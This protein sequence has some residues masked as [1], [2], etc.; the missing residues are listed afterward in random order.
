M[1]EAYQSLRSL[2]RRPGLAVTVVLTLAVGIGATTAIFSVVDAMFLK[3]LPFPS[4]ERLVL[5]EEFKNGKSSNG[6]PLRLADWRAQVPGIESATGFYTEKLVLTG[7]GD[8]Q[9]LRA[10]RSFGPVLSV[11][12]V[13]PEMG[14]GF[15]AEEERGAP[16][17]LLTDGYWRRRFGGDPSLVGQTLDLDGK[18]HTIIGILPATFRY[19][20]KV[21]ALVPAPPEVQRASRK[22]SFLPTIARLKPGVS[23]AEAQAQITAV[24]D[25]L[26][27]QYPAT[28]KDLTARAVPLLAGET[29]EARTPVF[30]VLACVALVL[31][32]ACINVAG[33]LLARAA[34]RG[35][36]TAIRVSLGATRVNL[37][38][39]YLLESSILA[40]CGCASG[41]AFAAFGLDGLKLILPADLPRL[42]EASLDWRVAAFAVVLSFGCA[43]LFGIAPAW[44]ASRASA[45]S[46]KPRDAR[47]FVL[48]RALVALQVAL[49]FTLLIGAGLLGESFLHMK[50]TP[51][52]FTPANVLTVEINFP[53][54]AG[55]DMRVESFRAQALEAFSAI[56]GVMAV[57][58]G[59]R[60]PL[61]GG[62]QSGPISVRGRDLPP[63]LQE[64]ETFHRAASET[65]FQAIGIP[66][67]A[68]RLFA[69]G[70]HEA[71]IND[72]LAKKFF[73]DGRALGSAVSFDKKQWFEIVGIVG[74]VRQNSMAKAAP[75]EVYVSGADL[76]WPLSSFA[77]RIAGDP[78]AAIP[79]VREAVRRIDPNQ[80]I[81]KIGTMDSRLDAAYRE[82]MLESW[83]IFGF[84]MTAL[85]LTILG[86]YGLM[87]SDAIQRTRE[88]GVRIAVGARPA[89]VLA[90]MVRRGLLSVAPGIVIG[91]AA[92]AA[93]T[94][95]L[96]SLLF[97]VSPFDATVFAATAAVLIVTGMLASYL[98]ARRASRTDPVKALRAEN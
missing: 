46:A 87:A 75:E 36:E 22:A 38:R 4:P 98:P 1:R 92:A 26:R 32:T 93:L 6:N 2:A 74:D 69:A 3:P 51:L 29:S 63:A 61:D 95:F 47:A 45:S 15:T 28:D 55:T 39:L 80:V 82:P 62:T 85:L 48:R 33:L 5:I 8:A 90:M 67:K 10:M 53:W 94:R 97:G 41:L 17:A 24:A 11:L 34:E 18:P 59:D 7:R 16:V 31:L 71:V 81:D 91:I 13:R 66:L 76:G 89:Q 50:H 77:L 20:E 73:P 70:K 43:L 86:I 19:P 88:I 52:G 40:A 37:V 23:L 49:S 68:G 12:G 44:Q 60:L 9:R 35:K 78:N 30:A 65:Y 27:A 64:E 96:A 56:P 83:L 84:A 58:W 72:A 79:A 57:G 54:D 14:R 21:D 42:A 25:R